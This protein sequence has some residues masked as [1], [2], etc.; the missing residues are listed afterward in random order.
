M[1]PSASRH[2]RVFRSAARVP[3]ATAEGGGA[4]DFLAR[5]IWL[6]VPVQQKIN[7][8]FAN[9]DKFPHQEGNSLNAGSINYGMLRQ[10]E[11]M[12]RLKELEKLTPP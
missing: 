12:K 8:F 7:D 5:N 2:A 3:A 6:V 10:A 4:T 9:Y 11:V 1:K